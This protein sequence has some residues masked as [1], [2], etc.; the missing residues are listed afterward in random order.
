[1]TQHVTTDIAI[2]L[3][4]ERVAM[5]TL[6]PAIRFLLYFDLT[7]NNCYLHRFDSKIRK[8]VIIFFMKSQAIFLSFQK[9]YN[10]CKHCIRGTCAV[11]A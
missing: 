1:M 7:S 10:Y 9:S 3:P 6:A 11:T 2:P 8:Q 5:R 4:A